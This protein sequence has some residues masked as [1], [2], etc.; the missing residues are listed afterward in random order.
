MIFLNFA[1]TQEVEA[2]ITDVADGDDV[3]FD[4]GNGEDAGHSHPFG[5]GEG[6]AQD[7]VVGERDGFAQA[8]LG[9]AGLAFEA[10][11]NYVNGDSGRG[12]AR[13]P[14]RPLRR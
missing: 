7:F 13:R 12:L 2:R 9:S 10:L 5:F 6:E 1:W 8:L 3:V 4:Q 11:A 14:G